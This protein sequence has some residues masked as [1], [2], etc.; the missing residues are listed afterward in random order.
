VFFE[1]ATEEARQLD[2]EF[3]RTKELKGPLHGVPVS[4]KDLCTFLLPTFRAACEVLMGTPRKVNVK[5]VDSTIGFTQWSNKPAEQDALVCTP[6][7]R[8]PSSEN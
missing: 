1:E 2:A 5:G 8:F 7:S 4:V 6:S 3:A